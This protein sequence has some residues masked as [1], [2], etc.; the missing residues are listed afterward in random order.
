MTNGCYVVPTGW[1]LVGFVNNQT[2]SCFANSSTSTVFEGPSGGSCTCGCSMT[3]PT[4][5]SGPI[6]VK[7]DCP[8]CL[9]SPGGNNCGATGTPSSMNNMGMCANDMYMAVAG[10]DYDKIDFEF[11]PP[12]PTGAACA[13]Q[14]NPVAGS[15]TY[16]G[17]D[18]YCTPNTPACTPNMPC[19]PN[20]PGSFSVCIA[21]AGDQP[22]PGSTF[23]QKHVVGGAAT[24]G[25]GSGC[26]CTFPPGPTT[27]TGTMKL[28]TDGSCTQN[29][30]DITAGSGTA[31]MCVQHG[32]GEQ[33]N[34]QSYHYVANQ[35]AALSC[36][37]T[38]SSAPTNVQLTNPQTICC[39][40]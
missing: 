10:F 18:T 8:T 13:T 31:A 15:V 14:A 30:Y 1:N 22:C 7:Y 36:T 34:Y 29:E 35:P 5:P 11:I 32:S 23:T 9:G 21:Q 26:G 2:T 3:Q 39:A 4:C 16:S 27:C 19:T 24:F 6:S 20:L 28:Y 37:A 25:C 17:Q 12:G 33:S 38:G 40:Q